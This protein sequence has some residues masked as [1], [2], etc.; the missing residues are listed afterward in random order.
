VQPRPRLLAGLPHHAPEA[1]PGIAKRHHEQP[2]PAIAVGAR[3]T[4]ECAFA[5]VDLHFFPGGK[6]QPVEL[7]RV[8][9]D[10]AAGETLDAVIAGAKT[11]LIDQILVDRGEVAA[12]RHLGLYEG[13]MRL[14]RRDRL[15]IR[16]RWPGWGNLNRAGG[17]P[18]GICRVSRRP[19]LKTTYRLAI[20]SR[21]AR[22]L[23]QAL[24]GGQQREYGCLQMRFQDVHSITPSLVEGRR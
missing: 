18:G 23:A 6:F 8:V 21:D 4:R 14:A 19:S 7:R 12:Q 13:A 11:E 9:L 17:H 5:V 24:A 2:R 15:P 3:I 1:A 16:S 10:Q 22:N 20:N